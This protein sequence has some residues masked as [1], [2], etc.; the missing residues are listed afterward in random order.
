MGERRREANTSARYISMQASKY[1]LAW[2]GSKDRWEGESKEGGRGR[3]RKCATLRIREVGRRRATTD[4]SWPSVDSFPSLAHYPVA[5]TSLCP[6]C[7]ERPIPLRACLPLVVFL[8]VA[9]QR[10]FLRRRRRRR[11]RRRCNLSPNK[12]LV[13]S[14]YH[15]QPLR[16]SSLASTLTP[17]PLH[18]V[19]ASSSCIK[20]DAYTQSQSPKM[21]PRQIVQRTLKN[22]HQ[23][24]FTPLF[25]PSKKV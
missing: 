24:F 20:R 1:T 18:D 9:L 25:I 11:R 8:H 15:W 14:V 22:F 16:P 7:V 6:P 17:F 12:S 23:L 13:A 4:Q 3:V 21:C 2:R 5:F 19:V 10:R